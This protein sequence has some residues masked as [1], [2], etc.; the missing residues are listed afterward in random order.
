MSANAQPSATSPIAAVVDRLAQI[1]AAAQRRR[2]SGPTPQLP[3]RQ[4]ILAMADDFKGAIYPRHFGGRDLPNHAIDVYVADALERATAALES[5][6][7][8]ELSLGAQS[9][10]SP[11]REASALAAAFVETLPELRERVDLDVRAALAADPAQ[12]SFDELVFC[13]P[14]VAAI[15]SH[16]LAHALYRLGAPLMAKIIAGDARARTGVDIHPG[17]VIGEG[18]SI[19]GAAGLA[20]G[21]TAVLGERVRIHA[22]A[23]LGESFAIACGDEAETAQGGNVVAL[24]TRRHPKIGD[25]VVIEAGAAL[26][27]PIVVGQGSLIGRNVWLLRDVPPFS[28]IEQ[29]AEAA[30]A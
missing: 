21:E 1:R 7:A 16:R 17:A 6:L 30:R 20:I 10:A 28:R 25:D 29:A 8:L 9:P 22:P 26:Y 14:A 23:T 3:S 4:S 2:Y 11:R 13:S 18:F 15:L 5:E 19:A 24:P 27:G 12:G